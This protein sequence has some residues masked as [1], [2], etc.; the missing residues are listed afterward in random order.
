MYKTYHYD[1]MPRP[2]RH[3]PPPGPPEPP[4]KPEKPEKRESSGG[5]FGNLKTDDILLIAVI[6]L[7]L[8]DDCEDKLLIAALGLIF[9][10]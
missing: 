3:D 4:K 6:L 10:S 8:A 1:N 9:F 5:L 2:V 7:L